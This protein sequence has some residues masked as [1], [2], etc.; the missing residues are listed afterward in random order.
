MASSVEALAKE[1]VNAALGRGDYIGELKASERLHA[2][3]KALEW[4]VGRPVPMIR[5]EE[6]GKTEE[7]YGLTIE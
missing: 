2:V 3:I 6:T 1:L 4:G 7:P 5:P